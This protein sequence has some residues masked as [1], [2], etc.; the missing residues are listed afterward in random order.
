[1]ICFMEILKIYLQEQFLIKYY[2]IKHLILPK[3]P[4]YD[5]QQR[6]LASMVSMLFDKK[7]S[8]S[9]VKNAN[10]SNQELARKLHKPIIRKCEKQ[11]V[12]SSFIDNIRG[13][14]LSDMQLIS[15][16]NK[17]LRFYYMLLIFICVG[18]SF[19]R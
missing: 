9:A 15:K 3:T 6:G 7:S 16:F 13:A 5:G 12:H 4:T 2:V 17:W 19:E 14:D 18:C 11:K 10:M 8:Q 1:M